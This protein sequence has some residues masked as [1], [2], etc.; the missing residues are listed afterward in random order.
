MS[1]RPT[2]YPPS[3]RPWL[4][5]VLNITPDSFSDGG[6]FNQLDVVISAAASMLDHGVDVLDIG[7]ESTRPGAAAISLD[8]EHQRVLPILQALRQTFPNAI[9]SIDTRKAPVARAALELGVQIV[10]DVSGLQYDAS[11]ADVVAEYNADLIL[12]HAQGTPEVMQL[13]PEYPAGIIPTLQTFF[14]KQIEIALNAGVLQDNIILD[15]GFG[16]GKTVAHNLEMLANLSQFKTNRWGNF[17]VLVGLSRKRFLTLG[18]EA[19]APEHREALTAS[20]LTLAL[21]NG[22]DAVRVHDVVT[23][24]PVL[25]FVE[26]YRRQTTNSLLTK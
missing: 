11:M 19:I 22:A 6:R 23:Q 26:A 12:M 5:G 24:R 21:T 3:K 7:G 15:P 14:E 4:M 13:Q 18:N 16:F 10:N 20:A 8:E 9:L 17:P 1:G 25:Q 2:K